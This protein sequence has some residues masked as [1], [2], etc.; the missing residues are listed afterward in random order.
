MDARAQK[1][2]EIAGKLGMASQWLDGVIALESSYNPKAMNPTPY[3]KARVD[4]YGEAPKYARGLIQ[5]IDE[6]AQE[7]GFENS[8]DLI[9]RLPDFASQMD[10][11]VYPYFRK[12]MPFT[13]EQDVYMS[14]FYPKYR[15]VAPTTLFP[16][17][18]RDVNPGIN[19]PADYIALV[20]K[21]V[22]EMRLVPVVATAGIGLGLVG[23]AVAAWFFFRG[24]A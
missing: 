24:S 7:L 13:S 2:V 11:A 12:K 10:G 3:N 22:E 6:T 18:V 19:T 4:K 1:I 20:N 21:R 23:V 5:F 9:D 16:D 8:K 17:T 14:V 15:K